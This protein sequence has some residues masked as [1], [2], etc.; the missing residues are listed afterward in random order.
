MPL[1]REKLCGVA[2]T[3]RIRHGEAG[4]IFLRDT[5]KDAFAAGTL[6][7]HTY[8]RK[9]LFEDLAHFFRELEIRRRVPGE[10]AFFR[11]RSD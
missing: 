10:L 6:D 4:R 3:H 8:T 5:G 11:G 7:A 2:R 1:P 9:F